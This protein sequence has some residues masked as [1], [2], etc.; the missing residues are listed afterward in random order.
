MNYHLTPFGNVEYCLVTNMKQL[1][2]AAKRYGIKHYDLAR[3]QTGGGIVNILQAK[4]GNTA[5]IVQIHS[6]EMKEYTHAQVMA[7][8]VHEA[9]HVKQEVMRVIGEHEPSDEFEAYTVD[10]IAYN[11]ISDYLSRVA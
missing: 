2:K 4:N 1:K 6:D 3:P 8:I 7:L 10:N 9:V 11:L 5:T